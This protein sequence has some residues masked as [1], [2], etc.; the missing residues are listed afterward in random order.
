MAIDT[1]TTDPAP[2]T[3][4]TVPTEPVVILP[5]EAPASVCDTPPSGLLE[6]VGDPLCT[7]PV[8]GVPALLYAEASTEIVETTIPASEDIFPAPENTLPPTEDVIEVV[9]NSTQTEIQNQ[10]DVNHQLKLSQQFIYS[11]GNPA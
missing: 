9:S 8:C 1:S 7:P 11:N 5:T 6:T 3:D 2:A 4:T 10:F